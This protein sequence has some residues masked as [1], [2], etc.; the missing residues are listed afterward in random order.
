MIMSLVRRI[1]ALGATVA[2]VLVPVVAEG[3]PGRPGEP[4]YQPGEP[5]AGDPYFPLAG[6]GGIDVVHYDLDLDYTPPAPSP[7]PLEGQLEGVA[8][9]DLV[10][11]ED[12]DRFNLDLRG[13][14]ATSVVVNGKSMSFT[15]E[16]TELVITSRPKLKAGAAATVV[17]T[18]GGT[19]TRP[20]DIEGALY[21]WVTTRDGAMV[22]SEP[23]GSAT[24]FPVNDH[25]TDKASYSFEITVPEGLVAVANG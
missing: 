14:T 4:R 9:I 17:V 25:P 16:E 21:G 22:V 12:L 1:G 10:A 15:Q 11:T 23:D 6:N 2:L 7:A 20:K 5:G 19:T 3:A 24:W 13:L 18:Y 8:T